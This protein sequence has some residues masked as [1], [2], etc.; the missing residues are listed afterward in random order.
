[1]DR[2]L[3]TQSSFRP[4]ALSN[5]TCIQY[6]QAGAGVKHYEQPSNVQGAFRENLNRAQRVFL[7]SPLRS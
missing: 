3:H 2:G 1:M 6:F 4:L 7:T 5:L